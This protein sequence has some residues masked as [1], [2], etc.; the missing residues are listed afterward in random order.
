MRNLC[1][2]GGNSHPNLTNSICKQ[3]NIP[4][5]K[6][7]LTKFANNETNVNIDET[8]R[9]VDTYIIQSG[10]GEI[11]DNFMEM[12]IMISACKT[13]SA[14]KITAV[15]PCFPYARQSENMYKSQAPERVQKPPKL[16][17]KTKEVAFKAS[18]GHSSSGDS[19]AVFT[20]LGDLGS[21]L[22]L[23]GSPATIQNTPK[24]LP[25]TMEKHE[26]GSI[27]SSPNTQQRSRLSS[28]STSQPNIEVTP[29]GSTKKSSGYHSWS[30][31]PGT[32][33][34]NMLVAAG[35]DHVIT[36]DLHDPQFQGFFDIPVDNLFSSPLILKYIKDNYQ[37]VI[38]D[39]TIVSP[40]AGGAKRY[41]LSFPSS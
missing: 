36:M 17:K 31:R 37:E 22:S 39:V 19:D 34:C 14:R 30:A 29:L 24:E 21:P 25:Y 6:S 26:S 35:C 10:C 1:I 41:I 18:Q 8:V 5:G 12:L 2:L 33:I 4:V 27:L 3:L 11:N 9:E 32:L 15:I 23:V 38:K 13:S 20:Q 16:F 40:D 7:T 28:I